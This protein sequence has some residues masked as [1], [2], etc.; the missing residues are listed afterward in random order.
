MDALVLTLMNAQIWVLRPGFILGL[1]TFVQF[2][3]VTVRDDY[4][5]HT[6]RLKLE[7]WRTT[8]HYGPSI[9]GLFY[10]ALKI[11][12]DFEAGWS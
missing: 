5:P 10:V 4:T 11:T 12:E 7:D 8:L 9:G 3:T 2:L 6:Y 1:C